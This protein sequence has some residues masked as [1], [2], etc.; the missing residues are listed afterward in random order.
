MAELQSENTSK[1]L[2][3]TDLIKRGLE[4]AKTVE[5]GL[6]RQPDKGSRETGLFVS[7]PVITDEA[8]WAEVWVKRGL[9]KYLSLIH[10]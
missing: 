3:S 4:L 8:S 10:I 9:N 7:D 2:V 6:E 1:Q 5:A